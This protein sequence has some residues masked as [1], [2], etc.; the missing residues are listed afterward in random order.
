M[1][2]RVLLLLAAAILI[3][4]AIRRLRR[5]P[6]AILM[7]R[8]RQ[9][10]L[11][12]LVV[13]LGIAV[14]T[15]RLSLLLALIGALVVFLTRLLSV[16]PLLTQ[17]LQALSRWQGGATAN[18]SGWRSAKGADDLSE[19]EARAILGVP[20]DADAETIR[21]AHRRLMQ[22]VHPDRGGSDYLAARINAAKRRLLGE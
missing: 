11:W 15:G 12:G 5:F 21:A 17:L 20:P 2:V 1:I 22:R 16:L 13:V 10:A 6:R 8:L 18:R 3:W 9:A 19:E 14:L 7:H 4:W